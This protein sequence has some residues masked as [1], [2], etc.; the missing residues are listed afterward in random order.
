MKNIPNILSVAR[1]LMS[2][3]FA[4]LFISDRYKLSLAVFMLAGATDVVDG[5]LARKYNWIT[6][7]GKILDPVADKLMQFTAL[8]C[9]SIR[10]YIPLWLLFMIFIKEALTGVGSIVFYKKFRQIGVSKYYGKAYTVLFYIAV[11][12]LIV[13]RAWFNANEWAEN[14]LC[15]SLA[16]VGFLAITMYYLSYLKGKLRKVKE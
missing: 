2:V 7:M 9:L 14:L 15:V 16:L 4:V 1:L 13:F 12:A 11:A 6:D 3:A 5:F 10:H 8:V